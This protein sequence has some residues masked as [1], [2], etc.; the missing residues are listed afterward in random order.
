MKSRNLVFHQIMDDRYFSWFSPPWDYFFLESVPSIQHNGNK[1]LIST[2]RNKELGCRSPTLSLIR[3]VIGT[4]SQATWSITLPPDRRLQAESKL[5]CKAFQLLY[6]TL[7]S[8]T[9][10]TFL[11]SKHMVYWS[12]PAWLQI[13]FQFHNFH[14]TFICNWKLNR[15]CGLGDGVEISE[16]SWSRKAVCGH[17]AW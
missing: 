16:I 12:E 8:E 17:D 1:H 3:R 5:Y 11:L 14:I 7:E 2:L 9:N 6:W 4:M 10:L 13:L 15:K